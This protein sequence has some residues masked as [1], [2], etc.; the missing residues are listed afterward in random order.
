MAALDVARLPKVL[1][2]D[3]LDGGLRVETVLELAERS[4]FNDLPTTDPAELTAWFHQD[5]CASLEEYLESFVMTTGVMQTPEALE[6][7]AYEA[8]IDLAIDGVVYAE[9]RFA[10]SLHTKGGLSRAEIIEAVLAGL[11]KG[12]T[13]TGTVTGLIIDALRQRDDSEVVASVA[14]RFRDRG[15]VGFDLSGPEAGY[16]ADDHLPALRTAKEA[17]LG[18]TIHAGESDGPNSIFRAVARGG[19][20]RI[21]HGVRIVEDTAV[22]DGRIAELGALATRVRDRRIPLE[23]CIS[24]HVHTGI[25]RS[26]ADHPVGMLYRAGFAVTIN[27]DNRLM[28][29]VSMSDEF[30]HLVA[31]HGFDRRDLFEVTKTALLAGFGDWNERRR[32]LDEVVAPAYG[33]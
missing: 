27:T 22:E 12:S 5:D 8:V 15:V 32:L 31:H 28:S 25:A 23:V 11:A 10:P 30:A 6:R 2:H 17:G 29:R 9:L 20:E 19:A 14:A 33:S 21:G 3:H 1:L 16:P 18:I 26:A 24:S 4:G 7:V 13:E